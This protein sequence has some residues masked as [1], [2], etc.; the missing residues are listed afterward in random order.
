MCEV[1]EKELFREKI[2]KSTLGFTVTHLEFIRTVNYY[3]T[4]AM[5]IVMILG[6]Y[7]PKLHFATE[8]IEDV[9][10]GRI[11]SWYKSGGDA[12]D[13]GG[14]RRLLRAKTSSEDTKGELEFNLTRM[15]V[16]SHEHF[17]PLVVWIVR[18]M[19]WLNL[20]TYAIRIFAFFWADLPIIL[21]FQVAKAAK[22]QVAC[23]REHARAHLH[24]HTDNSSTDKRPE[25]PAQLTV[26]EDIESCDVVWVADWRDKDHTKDILLG[27]EVEETFEDNTW[28]SLGKAALSLPVFYYEICFVIFP[29]IAVVTD[30]PLFTLYS[31]FEMCYWSGPSAVMAAIAFNIGKM[32]QTMLLGLLGV[33]T[34]MVVGVFLLWDGIDDDLCS[35]MFQCFVAY[36]DKTIRDNGVREI[37]TTAGEDVRY[38]GNIIDF[39]GAHNVDSRQQ[40]VFFI[41]MVWDLSFQVIHVCHTSST[42][43]T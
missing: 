25:M 2:R 7:V 41:R 32:G 28:S 21:S 37:M 10:A 20:G 12:N 29:I 3:W 40:G 1:V 23:N 5:H 4:L 6:G 39:F 24:T 33:Y 38:P 22:E 26:K 9:Y 11:D 43:A 35:N 34:W 16:W 42:C 27:A 18:V 31:L 8:R 17:V 30:E 14:N 19:S 36:I 15:D 13:G